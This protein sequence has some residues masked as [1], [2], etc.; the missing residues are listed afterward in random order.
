M[1][2]DRLEELCVAYLAAKDR[3]EKID[4]F[5]ALADFVRKLEAQAKAAYRMMKPEN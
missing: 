1:N 5:M 2:A 4:A 3:D